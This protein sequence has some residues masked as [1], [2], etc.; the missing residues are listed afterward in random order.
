MAEHSAEQPD[1]ALLRRWLTALGL[2]HAAEELAG[3]GDDAGSSTALIAADSACE[4]LLGI[5]G[6]WSPKPLPREPKFEELVTRAA[7]AASTAGHPI[8]VAL[9]SDLRSSHARRNMVVHHGGTATGADAALAADC[10]RKLTELLPKV[11]TGFGELPPGAGVVS[12]IASLI[13]APDLAAHLHA[14]EAALVAGDAAG[15]ADEAARAFT[16]ILGRLE[17]S[18]QTDRRHDH[19]F[20]LREFGNARRAVEELYK[21][22]DAIEGWVLALAL[23]MTP[24]SYRRLR[25]VIGMHIRYLGGNDS[26]HRGTEPN[27]A[28][29]RWALVIVAETAFR[30]WQLGGL[31][32]GT[33]D[34]VMAARYP[35]ITRGAPRPPKP[36]E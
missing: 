24:A 3:R 35:T 2:L 21:S 14:G 19:S 18:M 36:A 12:G 32:E 9:L 28:E 7:D 11:G 16:A 4:T 6:S 15:V 34:D 17:P 13:S 25:R 26:I 27:L 5:L 8:P 33:Q 30:M 1:A 23:G 29:A 22:I 10:A 20:A 31:I